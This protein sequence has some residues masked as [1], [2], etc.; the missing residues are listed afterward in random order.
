MQACR[1]GPMGSLTSYTRLV[2]GLWEG[3]GEPVLPIIERPDTIYALALDTVG[4][5]ANDM[6][7]VYHP[8]LVELRGVIMTRTH[9]LL[10]IRYLVRVH[11]EQIQWY[12]EKI[13]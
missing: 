1:V 7:F 8:P 5:R 2:Q 4:D 10:P 11:F 9:P 6:I 13:A 12:A 3:M